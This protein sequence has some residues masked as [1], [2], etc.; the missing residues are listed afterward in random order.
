MRSPC[1]FCPGT[2]GLQDPPA[3]AELLVGTEMQ[4]PTAFRTCPGVTGAR[5]IMGP[6]RETSFE[7]YVEPEAHLREILPNYTASL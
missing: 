2:R 6:G 4:D 1:R 3:R 7:M 5:K